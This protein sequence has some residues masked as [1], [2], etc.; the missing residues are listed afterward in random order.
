MV[1]IGHPQVNGRFISAGTA[2]VWER[3]GIGRIKN[4]R[5]QDKKLKVEAHIDMV[6][7]ADLGSTAIDLVER[8]RRSERID[9]S[10][11][12]FVETVQQ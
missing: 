3:D 8:I 1:T 12:A 9:V 4:A 11:G 5:L 2:G 7:V 10:V 6:K